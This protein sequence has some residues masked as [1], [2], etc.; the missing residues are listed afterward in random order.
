[1]VSVKDGNAILIGEDMVINCECVVF[2]NDA[3]LSM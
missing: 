3:K 2:T 1:M